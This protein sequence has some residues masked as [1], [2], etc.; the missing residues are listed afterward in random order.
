GG[1]PSFTFSLEVV[2]VNDDPVINTVVPQSGSTYDEGAEILLEAHAVD[3]DGDTLTYVWRKDGKELGTGP[4]ISIDDLPAGTHTIVLEVSDGA[5]GVVTY[6]L[7]VEVQSS[8]GSSLLLPIALIAV[9]VA[10]LVAVMVVRGRSRGKSPP[11]D[12]PEDDEVEAEEGPDEAPREEIVIDSSSATTELTIEP[13]PE[14][15][16]AEEGGPDVDATSH[17]VEDAGIINL[18]NAREF[19]VG[20]GNGQEE[21]PEE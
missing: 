7:E 17:E 10:I 21:G 18:E 16:L 1:E 9:I 6:D 20:N 4:S 15:V 12:V 11:E 14:T 5:G 19:R 3:E 13:V 8:I 2:N